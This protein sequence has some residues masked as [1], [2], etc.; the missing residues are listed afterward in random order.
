MK[1][2][3]LLIFL[4]SFANSEDA[5]NSITKKSD[6]NLFI[7]DYEYGQMLYK[8]PRGIGCNKCHG[9]DA[10]GQFIAKYTHKNK[11]YEI[12]SPSIINISL[13]KFIKVLKSKGSSKNIMPTYFL[14]NDEMKQIHYYI[15]NKQDNE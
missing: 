6:D 14:T 15:T 1:I 9:D 11:I 12:Y 2:Y 8:N 13:T 10:Q 7:T 4:F 3:I 5:I